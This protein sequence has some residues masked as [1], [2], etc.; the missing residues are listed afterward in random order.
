MSKRFLTV[1]CV[2][3]LMLGLLVPADSVRAFDENYGK[4]AWECLQYIDAN[5]GYRLSDARLYTDTKNHNAAGAWIKSKLESYGYSVNVLKW[6]NEGTDLTTYYVRKPG[7]SSKRIVVGAHY[8][9]VETK[10]IEDNGTGLSTVLELAK[11]FVDNDTPLTV[12]FC[13]FDGEETVGF[14]GSYMYLE[15]VGDTDSIFC[16]LNLDCV[17]SGDTMFAYGGE[18]E[19]GNL[20]RT[21]PLYMAMDGAYK[22]GGVPLQYIPK[23]VNEYWP[24]PTRTGSSDHYYFNKKGIPY[25]YFECNAWITPDGTVGNPEKPQLFNSAL[26]AF[27]ST[28]GQIAHK[29][30]FEDLAT[31]ERI[32]PGRIK[33]HM[34]GYSRVVTW[35]IRF[36]DATSPGLYQHEIEHETEAPT[37]IAPTTEAPKTEAP[38]TMAPETEAPTTMAPTTEEETEP[39]STEAVSTEEETTAEVTTEAPTTTAP[40]TKEATTAAPETTGSGQEES[41]RSSGFGLGAYIGIAGGISLLLVLLSILMRRK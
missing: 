30:E 27:S 15:Q 1:I 3:F 33:T 25:V 28:G 11:R 14:S 35:M 38:T 8:D 18:Y 2:I 19:G 4:E 26:P 37:T 32:A 5:L 10:G 23:E 6:V 7:R 22:C 20:V 9:S 13:F 21:W 41:G 36:M 24:Y 12:D 34:T 29:P 39:V 16:Y 31:L 40:T 17:G